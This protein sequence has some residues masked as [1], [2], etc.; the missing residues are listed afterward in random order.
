MFATALRRGKQRNN[1]MKNKFTMKVGEAKITLPAE[2]VL[3]NFLATLGKV[4]NQPAPV[5]APNRTELNEG[6][7]Y[8]GIILGKDGEADY[9]LILLPDEA[10]DIRW[11]DA[12]AC[13]EEQGGFLPTRREQSL[14]FAN[15]K[16]HFKPRWH[17]SCET[18]QEHNNCAWGQFFD[19]GEQEYSSKD[20]EH[21][22]RAV[23]R[24]YIK[25]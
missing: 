12:K 16:E 1:E 13:A 21:F 17:W 6:E 14:L 19:D 22:A 5:A 23:R 3:K 8:A 24:V 25:E 18:H 20:N 10:V 7:H 11:K 15:L 4:A 2:T 9:H